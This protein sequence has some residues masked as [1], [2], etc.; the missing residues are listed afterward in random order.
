MSPMVGADIGATEVR[1]VLVDG[2]DKEGFAVV[3]RFGAASLKP[4][5][6]IAGKIRNPQLVSMALLRAL[7]EAAVPTHGFV[8]GLS[9][10]DVAVTRVQLPS[11][12]RPSERIATLRSRAEIGQFD[13]SPTVPVRT[14]AL[15]ASLVRTDLTGEGQQVDTLTVAGAAMKDIEDLKAVCKLARCQ[16]RAIDLTGAALLRALVR[17]NPDAADVATIVDIGDTKTTIVT[18]QGAHLSSIRA[19]AGGGRELT[20][21]IATVSDEDPEKAEARKK[22]LRLTSARA[23]VEEP[24]G[25]IDEPVQQQETQNKLTAVETAL[26]KAADQLIE[27]I[28]ATIESDGHNRGVYTQGITL[29]GGTALLRGLKDKLEARTGRP[30][31]I[32]R[33]W[34]RLERSKRNEQYFGPQGEDGRVMLSLITAIGLGLW[35]EPS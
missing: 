7:K 5:A 35:K 1:V 14:S 26:S 4:G 2:V 9:S 18:R 20:R 12:V 27:A 32:G 21:A 3:K 34:A 16:P 13:I 17:T 24:S 8:L 11:A 23:A 22:I 15:S 30:V 25:Y 33:P 10:P 19:I 31:L 6:V 28:A 29:C